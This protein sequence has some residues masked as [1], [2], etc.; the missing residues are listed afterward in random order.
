MKQLVLTLIGKDK[1][2]LVEQLATVISSHHGNWTASNLSHLAGFFAGILEVEVA[3]EHAVEL[4]TA[5]EAMPDLDI[6]IHEGVATQVNEHKQ[7]KLVITGKDR[8]GSDRE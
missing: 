2:G 7:L 4:S 5:L 3:A 1:A 6:K 8:P